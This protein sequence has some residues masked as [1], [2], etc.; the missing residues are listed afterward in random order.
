[1]KHAPPPLAPPPGNAPAAPNLL[2]AI[3]K[4]SGDPLDELIGRFVLHTEPVRARGASTTWE[5]A[6]RV[7]A[8]LLTRGCDVVT[9]LSAGQC[10]CRVSRAEGPKG[11]TRELATAEGAT[12]PEA[13]CRAALL[14]CIALPNA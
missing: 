12:L 8:A 9:R 3:R 14:A 13:V 10:F 4:M 6:G 11:A 1:M 5:G 7:A 2:V